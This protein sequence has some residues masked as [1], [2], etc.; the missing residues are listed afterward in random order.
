MAE[1][2]DISV[3]ALEEIVRTGGD[4]L[5]TGFVRFKKVHKCNGY[6]DAGHKAAV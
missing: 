4:E 2:N 1:T 3:D 6:K 5:V